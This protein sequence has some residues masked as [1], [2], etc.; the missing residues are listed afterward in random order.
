MGDV[1][2]GVSRTALA[3]STAGEGA[4]GP[5][6]KLRGGV[7]SGVAGQDLIPCDRTSVIFRSLW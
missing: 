5:I 6:V 1:F 4:V 3:S 7:Q 2:P